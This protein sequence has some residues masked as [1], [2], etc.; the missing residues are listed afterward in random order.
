MTAKGAR[1]MLGIIVLSLSLSQSLRL[2]LRLGG[3]MSDCEEYSAGEP[4]R[5]TSE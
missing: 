1:S 3:M 5:N 4:E 2:S